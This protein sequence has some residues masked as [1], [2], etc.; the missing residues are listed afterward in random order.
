[1]LSDEIF[2]KYNIRFHQNNF[3]FFQINK[4]PRKYIPR[5]YI[6]IKYFFKLNTIS[7]KHESEKIYSENKRFDKI[8]SNKI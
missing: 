3:R 1:M 5:I 6:P 7:N 8:F 2:S 4:G